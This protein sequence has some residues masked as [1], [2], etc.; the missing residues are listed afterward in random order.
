[1]IDRQGLRGL[2]AHLAHYRFL[3]AFRYRD[4][5]SCNLDGIRIAYEQDTHSI[6]T[7]YEQDTNR[8]RTESQT[9]TSPTWDGLTSSPCRLP[10]LTPA[11]PTDP[12][13][14]RYFEPTN[15]MIFGGVFVLLL[16]IEAVFA[17]GLAPKATNFVT[18]FSS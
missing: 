15:S 17:F 10:G 14:F 9:P 8:I 12:V 6:R 5:F 16:N 7:A 11:S 3:P 1:M 13:P 4:V 2:P 18:A